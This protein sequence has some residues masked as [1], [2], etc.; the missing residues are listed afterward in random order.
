M[1]K[2]LHSLRPAKHKNCPKLSVTSGL[3]FTTHA[4]ADLHTKYTRRARSHF[5][6]GRY[7]SRPSLP[8]CLPA[9]LPVLMETAPPP[10]WRTSRGRPRWQQRQQCCCHGEAPG[11]GESWRLGL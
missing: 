9:S 3:N 11:R 8:A 5:K 1:D 6:A 4:T 10:T 7:S 2:P